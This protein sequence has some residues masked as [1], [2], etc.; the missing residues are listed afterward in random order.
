MKEWQKTSCVLC[1]NNC[2]LEVI[3][4]GSKIVKVRG[5]KRKSPFTG[6]S[7]QERSEHC[8]L[9]KQSGETEISS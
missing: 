2:G 6:L 5:E 4:E 1:F 3:T 8:V 9:S 7:L